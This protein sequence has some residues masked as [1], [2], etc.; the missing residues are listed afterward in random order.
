MQQVPGVIVPHLHGAI[1]WQMALPSTSMSRRQLRPEMEAFA[2]QA[3]DGYIASHASGFVQ[4]ERV[5]H[6][7][8]RTV[9]LARG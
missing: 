1:G 3:G 9:D 2:F 5:R 8:R 4:H 7:A 6:L